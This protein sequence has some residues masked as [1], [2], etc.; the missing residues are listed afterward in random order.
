MPE[1]PHARKHH[2]EAM[3]VGRGDDFLVA[4]RTARLDDGGRAR[5]DR[6]QQAVGEGEEGVGGDDRA[7]G[8]E[9]TRLIWPAPMPT[10]ARSFA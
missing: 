6:R 5:L 4:H 3:F 2:G 1:V 10:V 7:S 8:P 9:S